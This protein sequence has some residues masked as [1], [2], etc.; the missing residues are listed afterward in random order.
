MKQL[1]DLCKELEEL[2]PV[3]YELL[4]QKKSIEIIPKLVEINGSEDK[5]LEDLYIFI[6]ASIMADGKITIE[7]YLPSESLLKSFFG[8]SFS[9]DKAKKYLKGM[10]D[11]TKELKD[12]ADLII[13]EYGK[14]DSELKN[15]LCLVCMLICAVDGKISNKEK[16]WL[17]QLI[18]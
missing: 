2:D 1:N 14:L 15:D 17:Q 11:Q 3:S 8:Q 13:D 10:K 5:V 7:E 4:L 12:R 18:D 16:K 9:L 6:L